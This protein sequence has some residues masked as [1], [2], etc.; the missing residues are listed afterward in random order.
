MTLF[1]EKGA[2]HRIRDLDRRHKANG[3]TDHSLAS[4]KSPC[5]VF[6]MTINARPE[7][8]IAQMPLRIVTVSY[9]LSN[10]SPKPTDFVNPIRV[11]V[12]TFLLV[13]KTNFRHSNFFF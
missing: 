9:A 12:E 5:R 1:I 8:M 13:G 4:V 6:F 10:E 2:V 7:P 11:W 3:Y